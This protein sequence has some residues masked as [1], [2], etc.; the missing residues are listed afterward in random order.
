M[1]SFENLIEPICII[2]KQAGKLILEV[3]ERMD[4]SDVSIK[5]DGSPI[6]TADRLANEHIIKE[7]N[8]LTPEFPVLSEEESD[9]PFAER[10]RWERYWLVDPLDGT[11]EFIHRKNDFTVNIALIEG[12]HVRLGIVYAP[13]YNTC[14]YAARDGGAFMQE[15]SSEPVQIK[16]RPYEGKKIRVVAS[17]RH[18]KEVLVPFLERLGE[19][20][21]TSQG[22]S[23]KFCTIAEGKADIYPRF[24]ITS[25]WDTAAG[26]CVL[27]EA[28][29]RV[30]NFQGHSLQYNTRSSLQNPQFLAIGDDSHDWLQYLTLKE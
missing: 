3:Y 12:H 26:Q 9:I 6:T 18:A 7:L 1:K 20:E 8:R 22:S 24:G 25:E 28:G 11:K 14:Y 30:I 2:A 19:Y 10:M 13:V 4:E 23:L 21:T 27:Q 5:P 16:C 17:R 29:G 15:G